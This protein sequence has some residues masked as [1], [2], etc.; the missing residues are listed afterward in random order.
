MKEGEAWF[1]IVYAMQTKNNAAGWQWV[2]DVEDAALILDLQS[3]N[4]GTK[5]T[6]QANLQT[7]SLNYQTPQN[8][9][10]PKAPEDILCSITPGETYPNPLLMLKNLVY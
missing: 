4:S 1:W 3:N 8:I 2:A 7:L 5:L 6:Q 9:I 10:N